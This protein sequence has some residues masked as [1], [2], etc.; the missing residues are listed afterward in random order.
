M[1]LLFFFFGIS[2]F[3]HFFLRKKKMEQI[4]EK[5][6]TTTI[7]CEDFD[8]EL[9]N[10]LYV[11]LQ[12]EVNNMF[13]EYSVTHAQKY[14]YYAYDTI[15]INIRESINNS[16]IQEFKKFLQK[17]KH[18]NVAHEKMDYVVIMLIRIFICR[19]FR[20]HDI[21]YPILCTIL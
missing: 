2:Y 16:R 13:M 4:V 17:H 8:E 21:L 15:T 14:K 6:E 11:I 7:E 19:S 10:R 18:I 12:R 1:K 20:F 5:M 3:L 9:E